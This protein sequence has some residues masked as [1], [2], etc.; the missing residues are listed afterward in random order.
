M[1]LLLYLGCPP[2]ERPEVDVLLRSAGFAVR[3]IDDARHALAALDEHVAPVVVDLRSPHAIP[4]VVDLRSLRAGA[5]IV[6][7]EDPARRGASERARRAG[8]AHL[9]PAPIAAEELVAALG[10]GCDGN[11]GAA[12]RDQGAVLDCI[13]ACSPAMKEVVEAVRHARTD[14][15]AGVLLSGEPGTGRRFMAR[16]LHD[17]HRRPGGKLVE[18]DCAE[19]AADLERS[20]FGGAPDAGGPSDGGRADAGRGGRGPQGGSRLGVPFSP[21]TV[22]RGFNLASGHERVTRASLACQAIGGSLLLVNVTEMPSRVQG[23]LV[24]LLRDCEAALPGGGTVRGPI[25]AMACVEPGFDT[26]VNEG[27]IRH[28]LF[29]RLAATRIEVPPLRDRREDIPALVERFL[30]HICLLARIAE[31]KMADPALTLLTSLPYRGNAR[32]LRSLIGTLAQRTEGATIS[33]ED[34]LRHLQLDVSG[35]P[36]AATSYSG[37]LRDARARFEQQYIRDVL[38]RHHGR[39]AEAARSLGIQ[40]T[41]LY[42]KMRTLGVARRPPGSGSRMS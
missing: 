22:S 12:G 20:L 38:A 16:A 21:A 11:D 2:A 32:E 34:V 24:H 9:L 25:R 35:A 23:R 5:L 8:V 14:P 39:I 1:K 33:L 30:E 19:P 15:A 29:K 27:R 41:N 37:T 26:V 31:K 36:A 3:W 7:V 13:V 28:D 42:R 6:G 10:S 40:R 18:V 17:L 4:A